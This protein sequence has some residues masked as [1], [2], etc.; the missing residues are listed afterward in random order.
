VQV[1]EPTSGR[2]LTLTTNQLGVQ[3][4]VGGYLEGVSA[5]GDRGAYQAFAGSTLETQV[6][7]DSPHHAHFPQAQL[8]PGD[9]YH[10]SMRFV[11]DCH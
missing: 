9:S 11:F 8:K 5:K 2:R 3:L 1:S 6:F 4:Y 7:P 10:N